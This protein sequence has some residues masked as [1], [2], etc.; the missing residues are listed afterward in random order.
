MSKRVAITAM[1]VCS[2]L[3]FSG[4]QISRNLREKSVSFMR[5]P[6]EGD[7]V[8][9]P[10]RDFNIKDY[11]GRFKEGR[12]LNRGARFCVASAIQA[13]ENAGIKKEALSGAGLFIG[14]GPNLDMGGEFPEVLEGQI[15]RQDLM[16]LWMLRFLPNTAGSAIAKHAG[17]HGENLTITTACAASLQAIGEA[18]RKIKQGHLDLAVA[19][20]GDS[21]LSSGGILAYKKA[22]AVYTGSGDP[23]TASRP[24]DQERRGFVPGEGGAVFILEEMEHAKRRGAGLLAEICGY[25]NSIDGYNMTAP[26]PSAI[27]AEK[28]LMGAFQDAGM[29]PADVDVVSAHGTGTPLNDEMES[30]LLRRVFGEHAPF[31][32]AVKSWTGHIAAACGALELAIVLAC[33]QNHYLPEI[34][35]LDKACCS[36]INFVR[37]GK[38]HAADTVLLENFGFGGQN[39]ALIIKRAFSDSL[40]TPLTSG[41]NQGK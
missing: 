34:R 2:S 23:R 25:G 16:A 7:V 37:E 22:N 4:E 19:G 30:G 21:R 12:Y 11:T 31:V 36:G 6:D 24:F 15:D 1:G 35:N 9:C 32:I 40:L 14:A 28:A 18:F 41:P 27:W 5:H 3:G 33:I 26:E 29:G 8:V 38:D 10:V 20:G 39:S 17:I 13:I